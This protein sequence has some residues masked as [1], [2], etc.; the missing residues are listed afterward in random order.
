MGL[1][2]FEK[3]PRNVSIEMARDLAMLAPPGLA[4][5]ALTVDA[6]DATLDAL[7]A[8]VPLDMVQLHGAESPERVVE[9]R[10]R[11]GLPVMKAIGI[12][13]S[14]DLARS[15]SIPMSPTSF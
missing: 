13:D 14:G 15:T 11:T 10:A 1:V 4:K 7:M 9:V 3:S 6:D 12:A 5:V 8:S 2:F